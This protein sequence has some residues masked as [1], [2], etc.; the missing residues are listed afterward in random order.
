MQRLGPQSLKNIT[1]P[2][3]VFAIEVNG[4]SVPVPTELPPLQ[5]ELIQPFTEASIAVLPLDNLSGDPRD[6]HL[7]DGITGDVITN[8][9]RFRDLS[10]IA[11]H[12]AFLFKDRH[13]P[14]GDIAA[15]LGVRYLLGGGLQRS[16]R[17]LRLRVLLTEAS[18][19]RVVWSDATTATS[20]TCL[21]SRMTSRA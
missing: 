21:R 15:Q 18:T 2:V 16:G 6:N 4:S 10:V 9:S 14:L 19:E 17:K 8:L 1:E 12:S 11:R 7:C 3:E 5:S 20:K 13:L